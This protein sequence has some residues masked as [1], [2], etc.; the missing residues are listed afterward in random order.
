MRYFVKTLSGEK[1]PYEVAEIAE[2]L[3][4]GRLKKDTLLRPEDGTTTVSIESVVPRDGTLSVSDDRARRRGRQPGDV[5]APPDE[6]EDFRGGV[7]DKGNF[8][9]GFIFG[10]FCGCIALIWSMAS[11]DMGE[12]TK[13]GVRQGFVVGLV[14]GLVFRV[15]GFLVSQN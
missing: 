6:E 8:G 13:R 3:R 14:V 12:E 5:Y 9:N 1:G 4:A 10:F 7:V 15:I 11:K 2:S